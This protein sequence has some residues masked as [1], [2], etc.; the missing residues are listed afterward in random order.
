LIEYENDVVIENENDVVIENE[1]D[2]VG[3]YHA[4]HKAA[5]L[6]AAVL[7]LASPSIMLQHCDS[8]A[9]LLAALPT[10]DCEAALLALNHKN[11]DE[12]LIHH[13]T[14]SLRHYK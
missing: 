9:A 2:D 7:Q 5:A 6:L 11:A 4:E 8:K 10:I 13:G 12:L 14:E 3:F 1:I